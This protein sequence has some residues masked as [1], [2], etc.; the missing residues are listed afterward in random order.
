[1]DGPFNSEEQFEYWVDS[2]K[3]AGTF[4]I[5]WIFIK[6]VSFAK[7]EEGNQAEF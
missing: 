6:D 3:S 4:K 1:M 2:G 5:K 7:I